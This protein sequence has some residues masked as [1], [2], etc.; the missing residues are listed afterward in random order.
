M[1]KIRTPEE[2]LEKLDEDWAWR[3][4]ELYNIRNNIKDSG[5]I[6]KTTIL[7]AGVVL[8]YA[9]WEGYIKNAS[10]YYLTYIA[11]RRLRYNEL[12]LNLVAFA[13]KKKLNEFQ[14]TEKATIHIQLIDFIINKFSE[15][16]NLPVEIDTKS[17]LSS[18]KLKEII[19]LIGLDYSPYELNEK[20]I[21]Y[22]LLKHRNTIAHGQYLSID[23]YDFE[24]IYEKVILMLRRIKID[25][26][27]AASM[28]LYKRESLIKN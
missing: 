23:K 11:T 25:I 6:E 21:D 4:R 1:A 2:L 3:F 9:H 22:K 17:N 27:N 16:A 24:I 15:R 12:N 18:K 13:L 19:H 26:L 14:E 8:L 10:E 7:R 5:P 28:S 20:L